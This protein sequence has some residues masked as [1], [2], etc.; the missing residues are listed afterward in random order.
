MAD[1]GRPTKY[2]KEY[3]NEAENYL[4]DARDSYSD[5]G[6]NRLTVNLPTIEGFSLFLGVAL[7]TIYLWAESH[8]DFSES[9]ELIKKEQ[10]Q[11]V[12]SKGLSNEYNSTIAKLILSSNHNMREKA[13]VTSNDESL[14]ISISGVITKREDD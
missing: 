4:A 10:K 7:S 11:R 3:C 5:D 12:L 2:K 1:L 13:D 9:L 14:K 8:P 6:K